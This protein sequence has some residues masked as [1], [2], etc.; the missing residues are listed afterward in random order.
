MTLRLV[1]DRGPA[2]DG[3]RDEEAAG[4]RAP[5]LH[6]LGGVLSQSGVAPSSESAISDM[7]ALYGAGLLR[8][9]EF[10]QWGT[11][12]QVAAL[13]RMM[14]GDPD[15]VAP[16]SLL[17]GRMDGARQGPYVSQLLLIGGGVE[18]DGGIDPRE[19][20]AGVRSGLVSYGTQ[21]LSQHVAGY[22]SRLDYGTDWAGWQNARDRRGAVTPR[23]ERFAHFV[24]T[25]RDLVSR[26]CLDAPFQ[27]PL[28]ACL[29]LLEAGIP[30][31]AG[32]SGSGAASDADAP[33]GPS[34]ILSLVTEAASR[35]ARAA[36]TDRHDR[37][38]LGPQA[39]A[40]GLA[41][42]W[43]GDRDRALGMAGEGFSRMA[44]VLSERGLLQRVAAHNAYQNALWP[45]RG[46]LGPLGE[47]TNALL[48]MAHPSATR[49]IA[50]AL[51]AGACVTILKACFEMFDR[52][53]PAPLGALRALTGP[54]APLSCAWQTCPENPQDL[55][56]VAAAP[57]M[58]L[59][60]LDKLAANLAMGCVF[61]GDATPEAAHAALRQGERIAV[62]LLTEEAAASP[63]PTT[64]RLTSFDGD[65]LTIK[66]APARDDPP[67]TI[68]N[69][70]GAGGAD[71]LRAW[72]TRQA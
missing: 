35:A 59:G 48:P 64:M 10:A 38:S 65:G 2:P 1:S 67:V 24:A 22:L 12:P 17:R 69:E 43:S 72:W 46:A 4:A 66:A 49:G 3:A 13:A 30:L 39:L 8:D 56:P 68:W 9:C 19:A 44:E 70:D 16:D 61:A 20:G 63:W 25:P 36:R 55:R 26:V 6:A 54:D 33:F 50:P 34:H 60:E 23:L 37:R 42:A 58:L 57:L 51:A 71:A 11:D 32:L 21:R 53:G 18:R 14:P 62:R 29:V 40:A 27:A 7:A 5:Q 41:L 31:G 45:D 28:T 47:E 52:P 15:G